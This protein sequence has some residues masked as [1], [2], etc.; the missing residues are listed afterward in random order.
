LASKNLIKT[1]V[2]ALT[3]PNVDLQN[4]TIKRGLLLLSVPMILEMIMEALFAIVDV[5]FVGKIGDAAISV[6]GLTESI[7]MIVYSVG[8]GFST[9]AAAFVARR[10][11]EGDNER[12]GSIIAQAVLLILITGI[13]MGGLGFIFAEDILRL[14][15]ADESVVEIGV[16]YARLLLST[17]VII[18]FLFLFNGIFRGIGNPQSSMKVLWLANGLNI[19]LDPILIFGLGPIPAFGLTGAA[20]A[21]VIGRSVGIIYQLYLLFWKQTLIPSSSIRFSWNPSVLW[22]LMK[23]SAGVTGQ[24]LIESASWIFLIRIIAIFGKQS[25]AAYTIVFRVI[26]FSILPT[27]GIAM[28]TATMVGQYLGMDRPKHAKK[29]SWYAAFANTFYLIFISIIFF[30]LAPIVVGLFSESTEVVEEASKG[31][32]IL[33]AGYIPFGI[34]MVM[35]QAFNGAGDT[36]TPTWINVIGYWG[37]QIPLGYIMAVGLGMNADGVYWAIAIS[38]GIIAILFVYLFNRGSWIHAK[39]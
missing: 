16:P 24:Y 36:W 6:V 12:A 28:A 4:E 37:L 32:K 35:S 1:F 3:T 5:Y 29:A 27:W 15:G 20:L 34:A 21:T 33:C 19:V 14:M 17:N 23:K 7:I 31:L 2:E 18:L 30:I 10:I 38:H 9:A 22:L 39:I 26:V 11:G 8:V 13:T 25:I